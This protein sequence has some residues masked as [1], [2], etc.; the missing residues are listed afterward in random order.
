MTDLDRDDPPGVVLV[1][2][3]AYD[4]WP[5]ALAA[6]VMRLARTPGADVLAYAL[7]LPRRSSQSSR[8]SA[9]IGAPKSS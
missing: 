5:I 1:A 4:N 3:V 2:T 6:Q 8:R 7:D 9:C